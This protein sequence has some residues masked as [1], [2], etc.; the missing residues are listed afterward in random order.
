MAKFLGR[1]ALYEM[2]RDLTLAAQGKHKADTVIKGGLVVN[3]FTREIMPADIAIYKGRIVLVGKADHTI[4][5]GTQVIDATGFYLTPGL[6]D[7]HMHVESSMVTVTNLPVQCFLRDHR[8][9][10]DPMKLQMYWGLGVRLMIDEGKGLP[11]KVFS[12]MPSCVPSAPD[13]R[14]QE[15]KSLPRTS[16]AP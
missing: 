4:G 12:T 11:L 10:M 2:T 1:N 3:V 8:Y 14:T 5:P 16:P 7:G 13:L 6:L 9:F 15:L